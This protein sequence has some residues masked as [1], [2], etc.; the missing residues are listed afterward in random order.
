MHEYRLHYL[1]DAV[2]MNWKKCASK[3][4]VCEG[5]V[6]ELS[7]GFYHVVCSVIRQKTGIRL[8]LSKSCQDAEEAILV[9]SQLGQYP[10]SG[11]SRAKNQH[12]KIHH[13]WFGP[14]PNGR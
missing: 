5:D 2:D 7:C 11:R 12:P 3:T 13:A 6:L 8:D 1:A 4:S 14:P 9:A 10:K